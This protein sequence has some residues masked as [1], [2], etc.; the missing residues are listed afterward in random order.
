MLTCSSHFL[1]AFTLDLVHNIYSFIPSL[2]L[3]LSLF[4]QTYTKAPPMSQGAADTYDPPVWL[5]HCYLLNKDLCSYPTMSGEHLL[6]RCCI[7]WS[8]FTSG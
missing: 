6:A 4:L 3:S 1:I 8:F 7:S 5:W 2:S